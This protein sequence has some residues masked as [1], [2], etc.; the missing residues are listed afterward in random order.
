MKRIK[1]L[2]MVISGILLLLLAS[3]SLQKGTE[4][5]DGTAGGEEMVNPM[6]EVKDITELQDKMSFMMLALPAYYGEEDSMYY[7]VGKTLAMIQCRVADYEVEIRQQKGSGDITG[8]YQ[9]TYQD[10][11][12]EGIAYHYG[13]G[14]DFYAAWWENGGY[15]YSVMVTNISEQDFISEYAETLVSQSVFNRDYETQNVQ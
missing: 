2:I 6:E 12:Y 7:I 3:C 11:V 4:G 9:M 15:S 14:E 1:I 8:I 5:G 13:A 10:A